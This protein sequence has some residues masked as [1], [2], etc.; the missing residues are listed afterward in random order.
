M[1]NGQVLLYPLAIDPIGTVSRNKSTVP[2]IT[3]Q[4]AV[5]ND[6]NI[7]GFARIIINNNTLGF[8]VVGSSQLIGPGSQVTLSNVINIS[9]LADGLYNMRLAVEETDRT[10]LTPVVLGLV[11]EQFWA[12]EVTS[13]SQFTDLSVV[14]GT[15]QIS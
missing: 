7:N 6:G 11:E 5:R 14:S 15:L 8:F 9:T 10:G 13:T 12:L 3:F 2:D 4:L 1:R